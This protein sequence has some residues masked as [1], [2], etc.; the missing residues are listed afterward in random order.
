MICVEE[1]AEIRRLP[2]ILNAF[3]RVNS[4]TSTPS[5][6]LSVLNIRSQRNY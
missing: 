6:T 5:G 2:Y 4:T 3:W 1:R